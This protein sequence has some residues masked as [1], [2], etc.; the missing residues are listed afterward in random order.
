VIYF[1]GP[2]E[3]GEPVRV[4]Y[5]TEAEFP[6]LF[7]DMKEGN[8]RQLCLLA[9]APGD[10]STVAVFHERYRT[11]HIREHWFYGERIRRD[12]LLNVSAT[13]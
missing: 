12:L 6:A 1:V 9:A 8:S 10:Q 2:S 13:S 5:A 3:Y 11:D 4:F 7:D